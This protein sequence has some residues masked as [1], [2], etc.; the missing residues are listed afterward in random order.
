M[1]NIPVLAAALMAVLL[2]LAHPAYSRTAMYFHVSDCETG[3][4]V[5]GATVVLERDRFTTSSATNAT[6][7]AEFRVEEGAYKYYIY[8]S[9]Y[10]LKA[11]EIVV[12]SGAVF[13]TC[14]FKTTA[15]FWRVVAD[16]TEWR[17][18]IHA[19]GLGWGHDQAE[20]P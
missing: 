8:A 4:P 16:I 15:G 12:T 9:G 7:Y 6:G 11:G 13:R 20:K 17:G 3:D 5:A 14:L 18:D 1:R 19:G 2:S 10:R